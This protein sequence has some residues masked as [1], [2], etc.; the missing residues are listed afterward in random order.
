VSITAN[1]AT[2]KSVV[3]IVAPFKVDFNVNNSLASVLGFKK[4]VYDA[5]VSNSTYTVNILKVTNVKVATNVDSGSYNNVEVITLSIT[6][7]LT[8]PLVTR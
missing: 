8:L 3:I 4:E 5:S 6:S 7:S 2:L 1:T